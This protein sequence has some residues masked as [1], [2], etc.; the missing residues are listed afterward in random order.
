MLPKGINEWVQWF[1]GMT[2]NDSIWPF[3]LKK[4][5]YR[6]FCLYLVFIV[7]PFKNVFNPPRTV[8]LHDQL[9]DGAQFLCKALVEQ[10]NEAV[11]EDRHGECP[12]STGSRHRVSVSHPANVLWY[13]N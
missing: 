9:A 4:Q 1:F 11:T 12:P 6:F 10:T 3:P 2:Q 8:S 7:F 5:K 13:Q